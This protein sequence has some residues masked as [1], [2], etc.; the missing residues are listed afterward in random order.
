VREQGGGE[1]F[2]GQFFGD[3]EWGTG[4]V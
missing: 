1:S 2:G 4:V 3:E